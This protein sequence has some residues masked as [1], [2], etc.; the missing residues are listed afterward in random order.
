[1]AV[2]AAV[3]SVVGTVASISESRKARKQQKKAEKITA[4]RAAASDARSRRSAVVEQRRARAQ[5]LAAA[6]NAGLGGGSQIGGVVGSLSSQL[7]SNLSFQTQQAGREQ[8]RFDALSDANDF[9]AK[10][11]NFQSFASSV[12]QFGSFAKGGKKK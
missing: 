2:A 3:V 5:S 8:S 12:G 10:A 1:M 9:T 11:Q 4:K 6:E 7:A